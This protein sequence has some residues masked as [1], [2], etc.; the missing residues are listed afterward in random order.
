MIY[1]DLRWLPFEVGPARVRNALGCKALHPGTLPETGR[2]L[3]LEVAAVR[4]IMRQALRR[5]GLKGANDRWHSTAARLHAC[6]TLGG[7]AV[8]SR[9]TS[10]S[11]VVGVV[12]DAPQPVRV[13]ELA[14][15]QARLGAHVDG[16]AR[17]DPLAA[18]AMTARRVELGGQQVLDTEVACGSLQVILLG[19]R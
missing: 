10:C 11:Q 16:V 6:P 17:V 13:A 14:L 19:R 1:C 3:L 8:L 5:A 12:L 9:A 15:T 7:S 4:E 18:D 2:E